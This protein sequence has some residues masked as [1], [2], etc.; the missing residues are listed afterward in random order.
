MA[1]SGSSPP[2]EEVTNQEQTGQ[3]D[4]GEIQN[5]PPLAQSTESG[6][7]ELDDL[8]KSSGHLLQSLRES[9]NRKGEM[10]SI[11][12]SDTGCSSQSANV[13]QGHSHQDDNGRF[14]CDDSRL[15]I[16]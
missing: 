6:A 11:Q 7:V 14:G 3:L 16:D 13:E 8:V 4:D 9:L 2:L 10:E 5:Q 15:S 12:T 1:D